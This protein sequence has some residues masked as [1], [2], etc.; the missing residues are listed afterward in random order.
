MPPSL[1]RPVEPTQFT[2]A[3][4][5]GL[6]TRHG[7]PIS[8]DGKGYWRDNIFIERLWRTLKYEEV[9]LHAYDTVSAATAG[10]DLYLTL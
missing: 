4:F 9:Y 8:M 3:D 10:I 6:L 7:I 2:S 1:Q 5:T